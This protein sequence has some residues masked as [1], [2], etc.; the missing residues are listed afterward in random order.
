VNDMVAATFDSSRQKT[1]HFYVWMAAAC[2]LIAFGGFA[3]TYWLQLPAGTFVGPPLLHVHGALFSAW[4]VLLLSQTILVARGRLENHRAWGLVGISLAT[5]MVVV[6]LTTAIYQLMSETAAGYGDRSQAFLIVPF[7]AIGLFAGF[8]AAA[9]ANTG[10][11]EVHK[12]LVLLAT[13]SL[14]Q[15]AMGRVFFILVTGGGPGLRPGVEPPIPVLAAVAPGLLLELLIVAGMLYDWRTR[16]RPHP[17][18][19]IGAAIMTAVVLL[20]VPISGTPAWL[21]FAS[22]LLHIAG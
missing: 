22:S 19:L 9:I 17:V 6:G 15:A 12:R 13:I 21:A 1:S 2:A 8:F 11:P 20:R 3:P 4:P 10:R 18:W 16:G 7:T 5:A 14:L